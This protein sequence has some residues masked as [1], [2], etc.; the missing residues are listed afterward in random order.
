MNSNT[1]EAFKTEE[2]AI[3]TVDD[4]IYWDIKVLPMEDDSWTLNRE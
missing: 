1:I 3:K 2:E 4:F